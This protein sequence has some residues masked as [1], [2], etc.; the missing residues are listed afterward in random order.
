MAQ[1]MLIRY[2]NRAGANDWIYEKASGN[3]V[4]KSA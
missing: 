3:T 4:E 1:R 2:R